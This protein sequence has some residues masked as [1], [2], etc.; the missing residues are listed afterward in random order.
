LEEL[1]PDLGATTTTAEP[2]PDAA[3]EPLAAADEEAFI[4]FTEDLPAAEPAA[5]AVSAPEPSPTDETPEDYLLPGEEESFAPGTADQSG[6]TEEGDFFEAAQSI[7]EPP[8][9]TPEPAAEP[10]VVTESP[11]QDFSSQIEGLTQEWSRKML[12]S[13]YASMDKLIQALGD[14]APTIVEQVAKEIIPPLAEKIIK[15]EI[16]RLEKK[17]EDETT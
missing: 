5:S 2:L 17:I 7:S 10:S 1:N 11:E 15:A 16:Q 6:F 13:T 12:V 9:A 8:P 4:D 3:A 14:M